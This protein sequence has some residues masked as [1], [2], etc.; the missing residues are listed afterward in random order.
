MQNSEFRILL[1]FASFYSEFKE[2]ILNFEFC[3]ASPFFYLE[4]GELIQNAEFR[5]QN[6]AA[7]RFFLIRK[8]AALRFFL[9]RKFAALRSYFIRNAEN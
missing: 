3:C 9:I 8:F 6:F 1:R 4:D 5:I 2:L 7:L